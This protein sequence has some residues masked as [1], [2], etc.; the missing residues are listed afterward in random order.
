MS[1]TSAKTSYGPVRG[2][3]TRDGKSTVFKGIPYAKPPVGDLRFAPAAAHEPW[4]EERLCDTFG[5]APMQPSFKNENLEMSEDCLYLNIYTPAEQPGE[6]L[7]V[8]F[9]IFG[10]AFTFGY[11]HETTYDGAAICRKGCVLVTINYRV[12]I[13]G[14]FNTPELEERNGGPKCCGILDQIYALNWVRENIDAFGGDPDNIMIFGQSAGGMSTRML[15]TSPLTEGKFAKAVVHSGGGM[16]EGDLVRPAEEFK[17]MCVR[18]LKTVGWTF[19]DIMKK[20]SAEILS[21]M[22]KGVRETMADGDLQYFQPFIDGYALTEVPGV[23]IY[24]GNYHDVPVMCGTVAGDSWMFSRKIR[25]EIEGNNAYFKG[26][27][28]CPSIAWGRR[29]I[30]ESRKGI[31]SYYLDRKQPPKEH[32]YYSHGE[33][34]FGADS[35]HACELAYLFGTLDLVDDRFKPFD[36]EMA[37]VIRTYWTNFAKYGD[38]NGSGNDENTPYWPLFEK[39]SELSMHFSDTEIKAEDLVTNK[40]IERVI[41]FNET[42][43]GMLCSLEGF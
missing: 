7:P 2:V 6:K 17:D 26:F 8:F 3:P 30:T 38:P 27:A 22:L 42:H 24:N 19:E 37:E 36:Y 43:P 16:N 5:P 31:Y 13:F 35:P 34:P 28:L 33:P 10:G 32:A 39:G 25:K 12:N 21:V 18:T 41:K 29:S 23:A 9:W 15:L 4:T 20:D 11:S 40:Y 1:L 14:F